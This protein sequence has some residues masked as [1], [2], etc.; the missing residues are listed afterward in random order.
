MLDKINNSIE[1][2]KDKFRKDYPIQLKP[3]FGVKEFNKR[4]NL[5]FYLDFLEYGELR[6][7]YRHIEKGVVCVIDNGI[8]PNAPDIIGNVVEYIDFTGE[9]TSKMGDHGIHVSGIVSG[10]N[11]GL[12]DNIKI[13]HYKALSYNGTGNM[14]WLRKA[15]RRAENKKYDV[16]SMSLGADVGDAPIKRIFKRITKDPKKFIIVAAGNGGHGDSTDFPAAY[17]AEI[18]GVIS[19]AAGDT[20]RRGDHSFAEFNSVGHNSITAQGVD[21]LSAGVFTNGKQRFRFMSGT[22]Q[23][24]PQIAAIVRI[25][26]DIYPQFELQHFWQAAEASC[27]DILEDGNDKSSGIGFVNPERFLRYVEH[28]RDGNI[29]QEVT[30]K[31]TK[32]KTNGFSFYKLLISLFS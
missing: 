20:D 10:K 12:S 2:I 6:E 22:S 16:I 8:N 31:N 21:V 9:G 25:A 14:S 11:Y 17:S 30:E 23:A 3:V 19:V 27:V 15:V 28:L 24:A 7:R 26:K 4:N 29:P 18:P 5:P 32:T 1:N 13:A